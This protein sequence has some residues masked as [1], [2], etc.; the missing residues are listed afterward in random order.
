MFKVKWTLNKTNKAL[1]QDK[2]EGETVQPEQEEKT[3]TE[4]F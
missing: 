1:R 4:V 3:T 2:T